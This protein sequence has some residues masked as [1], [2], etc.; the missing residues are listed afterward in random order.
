[1]GLLNT[2]QV[3]NVVK[4][5]FDD[6]SYGMAL[7]AVVLMVIVVWC[8]LNQDGS[9]GSFS[10]TLLHMVGNSL[11]QPLNSALWPRKTTGQ[12]AIIFFSLY[13][14]AI[15]VMY[16][17]VVISI[18]NT[19]QEPTGIDVMSDLNRAENKHIR[20]FMKN[21][22]YVP[23]YLQS[24]RMLEGFA[25]RVDYI[26]PPTRNRGVYLHDILKSVHNGSHVY[27]SSEANFNAIICPVNKEANRTVLRKDEFRRSR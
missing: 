20:I 9:R 27:I 17:S 22:S 18:L 7:L 26:N 19:T 21:L 12:A 24:S 1:M 2:P 8:I 15:C 13:N 25:H 4:G 11:N 6:A 14:M 10:T 23:G 5:V 16:S 3:G